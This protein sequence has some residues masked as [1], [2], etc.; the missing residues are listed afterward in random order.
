[1][2]GAPVVTK[3]K[4]DK[5]PNDYAPVNVTVH[6]PVSMRDFH[7]EVDEETARARVVVEYTYPDELVYGPDDAGR[8]PRPTVVQIT[9]L[10]YPPLTGTVMYEGDGKRTVCASVVERKGIFG[11]RFSTRNTGS[12]IVTSEDA[13]HREDD[14][15]SIRQYRAIDT[16]FEVH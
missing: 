13:E 4:I 3:I 2:A 9:G 16:Y 14:G 11:R 12:C 5:V 8:G 6:E 10:H 1:V 7:F 15:W